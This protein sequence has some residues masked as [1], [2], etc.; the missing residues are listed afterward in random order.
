MRTPE[1][2]LR[3]HEDKACL[4]NVHVFDLFCGIY[5]HIMM[6]TWF[7]TMAR[8]ILRDAHC[9]P[10][11]PLLL[12][13]PTLKRGEELII[14]RLL[15]NLDIGRRVR[16]SK[17]KAET[18]EVST[19]YFRSSRAVALDDSRPELLRNPKGAAETQPGPSPSGLNH[20]HQSRAQCPHLKCYF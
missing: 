19:I 5:E 2:R 13:T 12:A 6:S 11:E 20:E 18:F 9:I 3:D 8:C 16:T 4:G 10:L 1:E 14:L 7:C 17:N 15:Y